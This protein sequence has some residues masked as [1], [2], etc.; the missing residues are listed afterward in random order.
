MKAG[1]E[2]TR[3]NLRVLYIF[4]GIKRKA[5]VAAYLQK[6]AFSA[7]SEV[8][9]WN[10]DLLVDKQHDMTD[11]DFVKKLRMSIKNR[12]VDMLLVTPPCNTHSRARHAN[13]AGP[14][15]LRSKRYPM[16]F[17]WLRA[18]LKKAVELGNYFMR[19][20]WTLC[21]DAFDA[22]IPYLTEHPEDLGAT[23]DGELPA[24]LWGTQGTLDLAAATDA[25]TCAFFQCPFGATSSKPTR[26]LTTLTLRKPRYR[27][28][29]Y[30][31]WPKFSK[32]GRYLGPLPKKCPHPF[33]HVP[34]IGVKPQGGFNT[35]PAA[36]YPP[37]M[38]YWLAWMIWVH[39]MMAGQDDMTLQPEEGV[40]EKLEE[41]AE[42]EEEEDDSDK[43]RPEVDSKNSEVDSM[44][45]SSE[46]KER[47]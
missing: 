30:E 41:K 10:V 35:T 9:C 33:K 26:V 31:G 43:E 42:K 34:L 32:K 23:A 40:I 46:K 14:P 25:V 2:K 5:D 20:T 39:C 21:M 19:T 45:E 47:K 17:P 29:I 24:S 13:R 22:G 7:G 28:K 3:K 18:K 16:G 11:E 1:F 37:D 8:E 38:C 12:E 36:A 6:F 44:K 27:V 15:P 4:A